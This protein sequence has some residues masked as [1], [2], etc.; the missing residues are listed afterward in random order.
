MITFRKTLATAT[1]VGALALSGAACSSSSSAS[2]CDKVKKV[3]NDTSND[4]IDV[5]DSDAFAKAQKDAEEKL[6]D[7]AKGAPSEISGDMKKLTEGYQKAMAAMASNDSSALE[8]IDEDEL[9]AASDRVDKFVK[10]K[11]GV[12]LS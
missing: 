6:N 9:E 8:G 3:A 5:T 2:W 4:S 7:I 1:V 12:E 10:E 11:C